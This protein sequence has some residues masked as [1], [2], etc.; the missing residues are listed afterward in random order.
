MEPDP[1]PTSASAALT[2]RAEEERALG[3]VRSL[4]WK[5]LLGIFVL[6]AG[7]AVLGRLYKKPLLAWS[8]AFVDWAGGPGVALAFLIPDMSAL[9]V[10]QDAFAAAAW[11][12]GMSYSTVV[13]WATLGSLVGGNLGFLIGI[14]LSRRPFF[15][16]LMATRGQSVRALV[17]R[18]GGWGLAIAAL[19]PL[20]YS[21][22]CWASGAL[23]MAWGRF[24][25]VSLLRIPRIAF[26]LW[27]IS[28]GVLS[29]FQEP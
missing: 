2:E 17:R 27:L 16:R 19:S 12:G 20:P 1:D 29:G 26:Y 8:E 23:G 5:L 7:F 10:P 18:Y 25:L 4:A 3:E 15:E 24:M 13:A 28:A 21:M 14:L 6:V 11:V 9:P 22:G